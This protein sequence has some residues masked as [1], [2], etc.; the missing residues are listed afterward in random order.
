MKVGFLFQDV[1][2]FEKNMVT[3]GT[4]RGIQRKF[5]WPKWWPELAGKE[6]KSRQAL[7][8]GLARPEVQPS[9][10]G[11]SAVGLAAGGPPAL[12]GPDWVVQ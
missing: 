6:E 3:I 9:E 12:G 2:V 8:L 4:M 1:L 11:A 7:R 5:Q 10:E